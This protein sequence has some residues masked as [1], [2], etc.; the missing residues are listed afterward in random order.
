MRR[1]EDFYEDDFYEDEE[2]L[3]LMDLVFTLLRRWKL[4]TLIAIPIFGLGV[5]FAMT[6]PTVYKAEMTMMV[7]SGRNFSA[8]SLDGGELSVNQKLA[9]TYAEIAKSNAILKNVI[10][11]YDLDTS[12]G[13]LRGSVTIAPV[14]DTE[15]MQLTYK[16]SDP[17]L[18]AAVVNEIGNEFM[19][20]VREVMNFQNIKVVEPAEIP[21][22]A[23]PKKR[24]LILAISAVLSVMVGCMAAFI[25]EFFFC[26]LRKPKDIEKILGTTMLGMVPDFSLSL[27]EGGKDGK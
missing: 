3:D 24:V 2:E 10:K 19:L 26:K 27:V 23:L 13:G 21:K 15:L 22:E 4:I 1:K 8:T 7:S 25:V 18:A 17:A 20:K 9:T 14:E 5:F 6:R 16:N 11:K 12:L